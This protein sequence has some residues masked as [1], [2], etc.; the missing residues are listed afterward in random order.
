MD[1]QQMIESLNKGSEVRRLSINKKKTKIV[2]E[3]MEGNLSN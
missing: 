3:S 2:A 1:L